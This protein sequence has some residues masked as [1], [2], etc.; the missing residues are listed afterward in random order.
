MPI[1]KALLNLAK[2]ISEEMDVSNIQMMNG[3]RMNM[4]APLTRCKM[5]T[6]PA[7]GSR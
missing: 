2:E 6:H 1:V 5:E 3:S 4:M 7:G